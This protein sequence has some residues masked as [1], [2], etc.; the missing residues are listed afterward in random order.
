M[1]PKPFSHLDSGGAD[2]NCDH[3]KQLHHYVCSNKIFKI[4]FHIILLIFSLSRT[5]FQV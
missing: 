4:N 1:Y 3:A 5:T 2:M